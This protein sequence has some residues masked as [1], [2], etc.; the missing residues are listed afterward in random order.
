[1]IDEQKLTRGIQELKLRLEGHLTFLR[2]RSEPASLD[3]MNTIRECEIALGQ[4]EAQPDT[5]YQRR[6]SLGRR[7]GLVATVKASKVRK[8]QQVV[9]DSRVVSVTQRQKMGADLVGV[10]YED[11]EFPGT[12]YSRFGISDELVLP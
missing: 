9:I 4:T 6:I 11:S 2:E 12:R 5:V 1:M 7:I 10:Y 3:S 8:G